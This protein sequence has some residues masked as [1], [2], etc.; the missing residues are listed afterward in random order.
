[1][2]RFLRLTAFFGLLCALLSQTRAFAS[3]NGGGIYP[4]G[5]ESFLTAAVPPPGYYLIDYVNYY[6]AQRLV[7]AHGNDLAP[8]FRVDALANA[9]RY[10]HWGPQ[11]FLGAQLGQQVVLPY[12]SLD[13]SVAGMHQH[14]TGIGDLTVDP[15]L[16]SYQNAK[17]HVV[18]TPEFNLP[19]GAYNK[20]D[21][22]NIGRNYFNFEPVVAFTY[23]GAK[24][25]EF[26]AKMMYD[27]NGTNPDTRY[28]SGNEFHTDY[29]LGY[30]HHGTW[31]GV[32]GYYYAQ[33]TNDF[34]NGKIVG[35]DGFK[36]SV[37]SFGPDIHFVAGKSLFALKWEH[38]VGVKYRPQ[39]DKF[40]LKLIQS[41]GKD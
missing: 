40:W 24:N 2:K 39:G 31:L 6:E 10:V 33:T 36:G 35:T 21:L 25:F 19:T 16:L 7:G 17:F 18:L 22:A 11:K 12:V 26:D 23:T 30:S 4:N 34:V 38:E 32:A 29:A 28:K 8:N 9:V 1:M 13:V 15:L 41:V 27:I 14:K 37:F 5:A 3:E 20:N